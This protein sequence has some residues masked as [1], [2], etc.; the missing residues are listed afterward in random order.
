[1]SHCVVIV[2]NAVSLRLLVNYMDLKLVYHVFPLGDWR[3]KMAE[4]K[5]Q[6]RLEGKAR[7]KVRVW[8]D[9]PRKH[10]NRYPYYK[11]G[12]GAAEVVHGLKVFDGNFL[13]QA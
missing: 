1:M 6:L 7:E 2:R 12:L 10:R 9:H 11:F 3:A 4:M 5:L 13:T 8:W